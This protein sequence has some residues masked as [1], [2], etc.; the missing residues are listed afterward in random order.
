MVFLHGTRDANM[1]DPMALGQTK[2]SEHLSVFQP[3]YLR[4]AVLKKNTAGVEGENRT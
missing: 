2:L 3:T 4:Q 1:F